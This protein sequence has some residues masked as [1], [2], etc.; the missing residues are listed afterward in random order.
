MSTASH[1]CNG[2]RLLGEFPQSLYSQEKRL[3]PGAPGQ[4]INGLLWLK[5]CTYDK[6]KL[7]ECAICMVSCN[8]GRIATTGRSG[9]PEYLKYHMD[10][11]E[12]RA[13]FF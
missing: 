4:K 1:C 10:L 5:L 2:S 3:Q 12:H 7:K 6:D 8:F 11:E 13:W 9:L